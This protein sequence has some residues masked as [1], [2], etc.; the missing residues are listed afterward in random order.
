IVKSPY[1]HL[2]PPAAAFAMPE[3]FSI[4]FT[5]PPTVSAGQVLNG[6]VLGT[7]IGS[8]VSQPAPN[9]SVSIVLSYTN[10]SIIS[11]S[12]TTTNSNGVFTFTI[13]STLQPGA[14]RVTIAAYTNSSLL[15]NPVTY[16]LVVLPAITTTTTTTSTTTTTTTTTTTSTVTSISTTTVTSTLVSTVT[17]SSS[18][19][20]YIAAIIVL[21]II[22]I[23]LAV[24]LVL[25]RR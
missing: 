5:V 13:P 1:F 7:P 2:T 9:T 22:I 19:I 10:G 12:Q 3:T 21:I 6:T 15:I 4:S 17:V 16:S 18:N 23:I 14:Y 8:T 20:G 25:R 24:L 11:I